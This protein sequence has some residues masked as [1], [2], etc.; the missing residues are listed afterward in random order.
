MKSKHS[1]DPLTASIGVTSPERLVATNNSKLVA[2]VYETLEAVGI[3]RGRN[4][5]AIAADMESR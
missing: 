4:V 2:V 3:I 5:D 1:K